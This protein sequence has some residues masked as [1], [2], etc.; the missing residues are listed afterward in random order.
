M[1]R[2]LTRAL[3]EPQGAVPQTLTLSGGD[4]FIA[5]CFR[6]PFLEECRWAPRHFWECRVYMGYGTVPGPILKKALCRTRPVG[7]MYDKY[8]QDLWIVLRS[9][10]FSLCTVRFMW[11]GRFFVPL[12]VAT[13]CGYREAAIHIT[14]AE[15]APVEPQSAGHPES[16]SFR[17]FIPWY[18]RHPFLGK[19]S[20]GTRQVLETPYVLGLWPCIWP[21][22]KSPCTV[23]VRLVGHTTNTIETCGWLLPNIDCSFTLSCV[24]KPIS[25]SNILMRFSSLLSWIYA[26]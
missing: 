22:L 18:L 10:S 11:L 17:R 21:I 23:F 14:R 6:R 9:D 5:W 20:R 2:R 4:R 1:S 16:N 25:L 13:I 26:L 7:G 24:L 3:L 15:T 8:Q 12:V 19:C